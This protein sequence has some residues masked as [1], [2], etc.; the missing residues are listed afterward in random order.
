MTPRMDRCPFC[1]KDKPCLFGGTP[2]ARCHECSKKKEECSR[3]GNSRHVGTR[4]KSGAAICKACARGREPCS[5]CGRTRP[6]A[7]RTN[8]APLCDY[9]YRSNPVSFR[10][11]QRCGATVKV[12]RGTCIPC[13]AEETIAVLFTEQLLGDFP[14]VHALHSACL[15]ADPARM[16]RFFTRTGSVELLRTMLVHRQSRTHAFLDAAGT[17]QATRGVRSLLVEH[18]LLP[19]RD[20]HLAMFQHW[21]AETAQGIADPAERGA[22]TRFSRWRHLRELRQRPQPLRS[23]LVS[24]RRRELRIVLE[25]LDFAHEKGRSL[26][27]LN[28]A[29]IDNWLASGHGE[30]HRVKAFL[31]WTHRN[32]LS[33]KIEIRRPA[34]VGL[35]VTGLDTA[36]RLKVLQTLLD[37]KS[38][39]HP[40]TAFA[41]AMVLLYGARPHHLTALQVNDILIKDQ[42]TYVRLGKDPLLLPDR[43]SRLA[44]AVLDDRTAP[45][46]VAPV[47][48][49]QWLFPGSR[50]GQPL[51]SVALIKRLS[52]V[53]VKPGTA[54]TSALGGLAQ[55]LPP[56][57]LAR[58]TGMSVSNAIRWS[59]SV[60]AA[61]ARYASLARPG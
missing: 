49:T 35:T 8:G 30:R 32:S 48:D 34:R 33:P 28:Q 18:A 13:T 60:S 57:I 10:E 50:P 11:C 25:L 37:D 14:E 5:D 16:L 39:V 20:N 51:T 58:L 44:R 31:D 59:E 40:A 19:P 55:D 43:L 4:T 17:D 24:S 36:A 54:R 2:K 41:S 15:S 9:C 7:G 22:F 53:G 12:V 56:V 3:C 27:T 52:A 23:S 42:D 6:V 47:E 38:T 1:E 26:A 45:R 46:M 61:N 29:D 21:I